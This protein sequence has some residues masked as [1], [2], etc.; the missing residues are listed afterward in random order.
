MDTSDLIDA[1]LQKLELAAGVD[2]KSNY[3]KIM[4]LGI[5]AKKIGTEQ[6]FMILEVL[7][8]ITIVK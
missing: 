1:A 5:L 6:I 4:R 3:R 2:I 8:V 7:I